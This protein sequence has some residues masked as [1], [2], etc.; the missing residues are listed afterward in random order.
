LTVEAARRAG[1]D[2]LTLLEEPLAAFYAWIAEN[3][4]APASGRSS[5]PYP[6]GEGA[7]RISAMMN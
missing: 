2:K 1:L 4:N 3:R 5:R 7:M 6:I